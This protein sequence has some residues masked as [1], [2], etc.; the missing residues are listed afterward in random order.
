MESQMKMRCARLPAAFIPLVLCLSLPGYGQELRLGEVKLRFGA[1]V[2]GQ[3]NHIYTQQI[4]PNTR[5]AS[6]LAYGPTVQAELW[7]QFSIEADA[8][9]RSGLKYTTGPTFAFASNAGPHFVS[10]D[11]S[12]HTWEI[13]VVAQWHPERLKHV[14]VGGG[15]SFRKAARTYHF[16]DTATTSAFGPP[17]TSIIEFWSSIGDEPH[18]WTYGGVAAAGIDLHKGVFH[19]RPQIRYTRWN[20]SPSHLFMKRDVVQVVVG[21]S[22]GK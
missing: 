12:A 19:V 16:Y 18:A 20:E 14:F 11:V 1:V 7:H 3:I 13:P 10:T 9:Y 2:A 6:P 15:V 8:L 22:L 21:V 17:M 4:V 5:S